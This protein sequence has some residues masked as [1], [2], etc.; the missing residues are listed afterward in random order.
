MFHVCLLHSLKVILHN[1][2][3]NFVYEIKFYGMALKEI[4]DLGD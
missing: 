1:I 4:S 2:F 3:F